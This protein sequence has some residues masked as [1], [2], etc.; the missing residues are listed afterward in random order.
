MARFAVISAPLPAVQRLPLWLPE[1]VKS[2]READTWMERNSEWVGREYPNGSIF[3]QASART[4]RDVLHI[5]EMV[6]K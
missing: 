5:D 1:D 6:D 3:V 2:L 4:H